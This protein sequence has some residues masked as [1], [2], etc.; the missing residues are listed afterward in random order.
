ME[1]GRLKQI[2]D[3]Y[4][5]PVPSAEIAPA[6]LSSDPFKS[7]VSGNELNDISLNSASINSVHGNQ[8]Q[9][10]LRA[11]QKKKAERE[12]Q[13][14]MI[15]A[16]AT[17][18][19]AQQQFVAQMDTIIEGYND[20]ISD[21]DREIAAEQEK[22]DRM[23]EIKPVTL[24]D[25]TIA[26]LDNNTGQFVKLDQAGHIEELNDKQ[27]AEAQIKAQDRNGPV[28]G[29][30]DQMIIW[31]TQQRI[32][33]LDNLRNEAQEYRADD[34]GHRNN[35]N[36]LSDEEAHQQGQQS[37]IRY[38]DLRKR[39][40]EEINQEYKQNIENNPSAIKEEQKGYARDLHEE[41]ALE[42]TAVSDSGFDM[43]R[44]SGF[45][46]GGFSPERLSATD[47]AIKSSFKLSENFNAEVTKEPSHNLP[48]EP[49]PAHSNTSLP[50]VSV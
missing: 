12:G 21:L 17:L 9:Q 16:M 41:D 31:A 5:G 19:S 24:D 30:E 32:T 45:N 13:D 36:K 28:R 40:Q 38:D 3:T 22:L 23:D 47:P 50:T 4:T 11:E 42:A 1:Q 20:I 8:N 48:E 26:Y 43:S 2:W 14:A 29:V 27:Q 18:T 25:G 39:A 35:A 46:A 6:H 49:D 10:A 15:Q 34:R 44:L 7:F 37:Q 33:K